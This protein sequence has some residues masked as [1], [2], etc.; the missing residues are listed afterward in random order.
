IDFGDGTVMLVPSGMINYKYSVPGT[1]D[2]TIT[3]SAI[4]TGGVTSVISKKVK[5]YVAFEIPADIV[6]RLTGGASKVWVTDK[7]AI[8]HVGVSVD[9]ALFY[10]KDYSATANSRSPELYDDEIT[11][12]ADA[13][14]NIS[15]TV[16]NKGATSMTAAS[17]AFYGFSGPDGAYPLDPGGTKKLIFS[18]ANSGSTADV[19]TQI[20]FH[21]PGN[22]IVNFGTG[23]TT[24]EILSI[25]D[26]Q[27]TLRNI[28][29]DGLAWFQKLKVK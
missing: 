8:G 11:F 4:G 27:L 14:N 24:Y 12:T 20:Q 17:T 9:P 13:N 2:Y 7:E 23:G 15:M 16:D 29:A 18:N 3:A 5:V 10:S 1:F 25:S 28:G 6:A 22:G 21:V 26:T 19:S